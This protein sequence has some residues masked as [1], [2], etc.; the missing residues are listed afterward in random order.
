MTEANS[1]KADHAIEAFFLERWSPRAFLAEPMPDEDLRILFEA[2]RWAPSSSNAQPWRFLYAKRE[3]PAFAKFLG[4]L[5]ASNQV[6]AK[7]A[8]VLAVLI[9]Q[10]S[11]TPAGK[12][13]PVASHSHSFDAGAAWGFLALQASRSGYAAH[14]MIGFDIPRAAVDL[15][16]PDD[17]RVEMA[18]A[19]GRVGD[20]SL[21]PEN[22]RAREHPSG[23]NPQADFVFEGGFPLA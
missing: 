19:V 23:R 4:L 18:F 7:N 15:N 1:R 2:A 10:K 20:K 22:L 21:L 11:F 14:G 17:Y 8:S 13:E 6:W 9:S 12:S 16:V 5:A 3:T